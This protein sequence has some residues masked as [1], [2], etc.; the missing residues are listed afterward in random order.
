[1]GDIL[2]DFDGAND[3]VKTMEGEEVLGDTVGIDVIGDIDGEL[4]GLE[5]GDLEGIEV[6]GVNVGVRS[7][8]K[9]IRSHLSSAP[10]NE[11]LP[12]LNPLLK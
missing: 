6:V 8:W 1:V 10:R 4:E 3:V 9:R 7:E 5:V 2:G 11:W 12:H